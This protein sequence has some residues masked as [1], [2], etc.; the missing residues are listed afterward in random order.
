MPDEESSVT[1][2]LLW[3]VVA[4]STLLRLWLAWGFL[5][6]VTGDD[7]EVLEAG[8]QGALGL[9]YRPWEIR[10]LLMPEL[11]VRPVIEV[12][13]LAGVESPGALVR[14]ALLPFVLLGSLSTWLVFR[15]GELWAR[16]TRVGLL[17]ATLYAFHPLVLGYAS[18]A[19]P[20]VP[21][22]AAVLGA[23]F[24]AS[25]RGWNLAR[26]IA[27]GALMALA[28]ACRYSEVT[29]L[30]PVAL[31]AWL[32]AERASVRWRRLMGLVA[33]F[34][35]GVVMALG[36]FDLLTWGRPFGSLVEF[37]RYTL[38]ERQASAEMARQPLYWYLWR[39]SRWLPL[40]LLPLLWF[41]PRRRQTATAWVFVLWPLLVLS[42]IH[43]KDLRYT[44]S[45]L[46]FVSLLAAAGGM[47]LADRGRRKTV[48]VLVALAVAYGLGAGYGRAQR[49][50]LAAVAAAERLAGET[51]V[52]SVVLS[53]AWA[54]GHRLFL[55]NDVAI[56]DLPVRP[57][58]AALE[59]ALAGPDR[60]GLYL[61]DVE[62][63]P[64]LESLLADRGFTRSE[65]V[66][67]G[68]SKAVVLYAPRSAHSRPS[69]SL[70]ASAAP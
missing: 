56:G 18:T 66:A 54:W 41:V 16:D 62:A 45:L 57:S 1:R 13:H 6:F 7:V 46:P 5:G 58:P 15:L 29:L 22:V 64:E 17:A 38:V 67:R 35:L 51:G 21:A 47:A 34:T 3:A 2:R 49:R 32:S 8:F 25:G 19:L 11:V 39:L 53:Q 33:G 26:G 31:L 20:R 63:S 14:L 27:A 36:L 52:R 4:G 65:V 44:Q 23:A 68:G 50:S 12:A 42:L 70:P 59:R 30:L 43:H 61:S 69:I 37:A 28:T 48:A 55:G 40:S 9:E 24:L 10:N 60:V